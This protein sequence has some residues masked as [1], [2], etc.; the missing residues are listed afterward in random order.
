VRKRPHLYDH[1]SETCYES[2]F[3]NE[4]GESE[5]ALLLHV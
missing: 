3:V 1:D 2:G 5:N 4:I